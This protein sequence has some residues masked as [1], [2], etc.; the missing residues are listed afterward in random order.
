[1]KTRFHVFAAGIAI[2]GGL[3]LAAGPSDGTIPRLP[4]RTADEPGY[5]YHP[6]P[7]DWRSVP[8]YQIITDRFFD[9]D[10][11]NNQ[12]AADSVFN[13]YSFDSRHGGDFAGL[14]DQLDYVA[15]LG[16]K[17]IWISPVFLNH[18]GAYHGYHISDFNR[19]D[20]HWGSLDELRLL[21][22]EAHARGL[23]VII[24]V[25]FNHMAR[26]LTSDDPGFPTFS[27]TPYAMRWGDPQAVFPPPFNDISLFHG[28]GSI[29]DWENDRQN[30]IGDLQGL[31]DLRTEDPRI[32]RW[33][34]DSHLAL[35]AATD[36]DGFRVDTAHHV[37]MDFWREVLPALRDGAALLGKTNFLIFAEALR[38]RDE[39]VSRLTR[40]AAFPSALYYPYYF[41]LIEVWRNRG[42]TRQITDRWSRLPEYGPA[43]DN[44]LVG[45][46]DNH[47]RARLLND[48][49]LDGDTNRLRAVLTL[50]YASPAIPCVYYGTEQGFSGSKGHRAREP[51]FEAGASP[52]P[53]HFNRNHAHYRLIQQLNRVRDLY[54]ALSR[55][56]LTVIADEPQAGRF[57]FTRSLDGQQ[58]VVAMN[59][60]TTAVPHA[61]GETLVD[62]LT[63]TP[64]NGVIPADTTL[65]LVRPSEHQPLAPE[66]VVETTTLVSTAP[67]LNIPFTADGWLDA[68]AHPV[69]TGSITTLH[70]AYDP[71][72]RLAYVAVDPAPVGYDRFILV[73]FDASTN[74]Y[75]APWQKRGDVPA[76]Q[77]IISDEGDSDYTSVRGTT[78]PH[79]SIADQHGVLEAAFE[80]PADHPGTIHVWT[81]LYGTDDRAEEI[82]GHRLPADGGMLAIPLSTL[83]APPA[84]IT[85]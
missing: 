61:T 47:D 62:A 7:A 75:A 69:A 6:S 15:E 41:T 81:S 19:I 25:V 31:A 77:V 74:R 8:I 10:P 4:A 44:L 38:G 85:P 42:P 60:S 67:S 50:L 22:D 52:S 30:V 34:L 55:G 57:V 26:V 64:Y 59:N 72:T 27:E 78:R 13:P 66:P 35:I 28:H 24:D 58:I 14:R 84:A 79:W 49:Y 3:A 17:A 82:P 2:L 54:P 70:A 40:E 1:M 53:V 71:A 23:Y 16:F 36:C 18:R 48:S 21:V 45:F 37:E 65:L 68:V 32:R 20:P 83:P 46:A 51:M 56:D 12:M 80:V 76:Y 9:G 73:Q 29:N 33:L 5:R 63:G 39:D 11:S 43:G